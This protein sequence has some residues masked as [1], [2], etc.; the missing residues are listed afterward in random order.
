MFII[1]FNYKWLIYYLVFFLYCM[2]YYSNSNIMLYKE[3]VLNVYILY[4][5]KNYE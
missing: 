2:Y 1:E 4:K 3:L 5:Y